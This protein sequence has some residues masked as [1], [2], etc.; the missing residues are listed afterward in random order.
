MR[1]AII[2]AGL[3]G[4][5]AARG[6]LM[7]GLAPI[8]FDKGRGVGGRL[9]T[10][11]AEG[12]VQFDHGAQY[13]SARAPG[14]DAFLRDLEAA[15]AAGRW[16]LDDGRER[17]VGQPGMSAVARYQARGVDIRQGVEIATLERD[18]GGWSVAGQRFDR[19]IST[20]PAP[21]AVRLIGTA[22]PAAEALNGVVME[23]GLTL[24]LA[25][26]ARSDNPF[27]TCST[28]GEAI[29][30]LA[31]DSSKPGRGGAD[32]WVAQ[33]SPDWSRA[34][35]ERGSAEIVD[36]MLPL[37]CDRLAADPAGALHVSGHRWRFARASRPLGQPCLTAG[38][39]VFFGGDWALSD[40][41]EAAWDSGGALARAVLES[42]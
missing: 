16:R 9:S 25:L 20:V 18:G 27:R 6:L 40:R 17:L 23:P 22:H 19:V 30:W 34:H 26:P 33:A 12:G 36:L 31:L 14:F 38:D 4:L 1:V 13:L 7:A 5:T 35:L 39:G 42:R 2:G 29:A 8:V 24:M 10:R 15:G 11:R 32:C 21:Q 41:A 3:A 28:A 37:V